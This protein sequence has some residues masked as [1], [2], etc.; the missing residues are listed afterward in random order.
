VVRVD[1]EPRAIHACR[2]RF[3]EVLR[4]RFRNDSWV[5]IGMRWWLALAFAAVAATTVV[6]VAQVSSTGSEDQFRERAQQLAAGSAFEAAIELRDDPIEEVAQRRRLA[7]FLVDRNGRLTSAPRS[8][9]VAFSMVPGVGEAVAEALEGRRTVRTDATVRATTVALPFPSGRARALVAYVSH[10]DLATELGI[11][12]NEI[13]RAAWLALVLGGLVGA[14]IASLIARRLRRIAHAAAAMEQGDLNTPVRRD[15]GDE[16][17]DLAVTVDRM[18]ERLRASFQQLESDR[19]RLERLLERLQEGVLA[20]DRELNVQF[21]NRVALQLVAALEP[22]RELPETGEPLSLRAFA[23][24][25]YERG[26]V[27]ERRVELPDERVFTVVGLPPGSDDVAVIV[28][29]DLTEEERRERVEREFVANA[30]HELRT[31]VTTI[32]GAV[33]VLR[34]GAKDDPAELDRFLAHVER[35]AR[36]LVRLSRALLVLARAQSREEQPRLAAVDVRPLLERVAESLRVRPGVAVRVRCARGLRVAADRDLLEQAV[37]NLAGNAAE[38]TPEGEITLA[39]EAD[40]NGS[41]K[42]AVHDTGT[43]I[44]PELRQRIF[45]RFYRPP[46]AKSDGFGLGLAIAREAVEAQGGS[47]G[48]SSGEARGTTVTIDLARAER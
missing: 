20:V 33:E 22:G 47:L 45:E 26:T 9:G 18:R 12:H 44:A 37:V 35:E 42:I 15:F 48:I 38:H 8:H 31:P 21:S 23:T 6:A 34:D 36:R 2:S 1:V 27:V 28:V 11:V 29:R 32:L 4:G 3:L 14:V 40:G 41:V 25:L 7:L 46:A 17:G 39:A 13:T 24:D 19:D 5:R 43:G 16:V 10:P 30:A